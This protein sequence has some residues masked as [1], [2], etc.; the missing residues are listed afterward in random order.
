M[1]NEHARALTKFGAINVLTA[2]LMVV[3]L[4]LSSL[5]I[6]FAMF[7]DDKPSYEKANYKPMMNNYESST[8]NLL[9]A[10]SIVY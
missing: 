8:C 1:H 7:I 10:A 4:I 2:D 3:L 5:S 9:T 6:S